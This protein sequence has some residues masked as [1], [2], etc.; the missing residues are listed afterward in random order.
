MEPP[1]PSRLD[2]VLLF[3]G[4]GSAFLC[5]LSSAL[6][7]K[8]PLSPFSSGAQALPS[9]PIVSP[10]ERRAFTSSVGPCFDWPTD[11]RLQPTPVHDR[12]AR[13]A[14]TS[15][16]FPFRHLFSLVLENYPAPWQGALLPTPLVIC[17]AILQLLLRDMFEYLSIFPFRRTDRI[18]NSFCVLALDTVVFV[19]YCD[20]STVI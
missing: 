4:F 8:S 2:A 20:Y 6:R 9:P 17:T 3:V 18:P 11:A 14:M 13:F 16:T 10:G 7:G 5:P 1:F 19:D 12:Y 15:P